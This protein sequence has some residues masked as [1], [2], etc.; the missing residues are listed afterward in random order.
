MEEFL[1]T[2]LATLNDIEVK[3]KQNMNLLL[4][5]I[6]ATEQELATLSAEESTGEIINEEADNGG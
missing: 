5:A 2:L 1:R 4:G 3:G 6:M